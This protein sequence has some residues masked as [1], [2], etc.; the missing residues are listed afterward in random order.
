MKKSNTS[1]KSG[2][3]FERLAAMKDEDIDFSDLPEATEEMFAR[4]VVRPPLSVTEPR[5]QLTVMIDRDVFKWFKSL[6]P[7][8][9]GIINFVLRRYMQEEL[10]KPARPKARRA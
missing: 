1:K 10:G 3:D 8:Y 5:E 4:A 6:G 9:S 7:G 2:T